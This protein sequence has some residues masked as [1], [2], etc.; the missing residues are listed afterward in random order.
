MLPPPCP[1]G[2]IGSLGADQKN[3]SLSERDW[4]LPLYIPALYYFNDPGV[5]VVARESL[6]SM[7]YGKGVQERLEHSLVGPWL[8]TALK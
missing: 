5:D 4:D 3:L 8:F 7:K 6:N 2:K 1:A